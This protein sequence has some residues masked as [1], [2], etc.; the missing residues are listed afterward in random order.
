MGSSCLYPSWAQ[1]LPLA[2]SLEC[3]GITYCA[4]QT[5]PAQPWGSSLYYLKSLWEMRTP[6]NVYLEDKGWNSVSCSF[7]TLAWVH[8]HLNSFQRVLKVSSYSGSWINPLEIVGKCQFPVGRVPSWSWIWPRFGG[9]F[10]AISSHCARNA[11][12]WFWKRFHW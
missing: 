4:W 8:R 2:L 1:L 12:S 5:P 3:Q 11:H 9:H 7:F 10:M 6:R